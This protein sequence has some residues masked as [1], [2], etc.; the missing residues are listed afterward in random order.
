MWWFW[1]LRAGKKERKLLGMKNQKKRGKSARNGNMPAPYT[2]YKKKPHQ[3][4]SS[5]RMD[6][7]ISK[8]RSLGI[9]PVDYLNGLRTDRNRREAA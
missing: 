1:R 5:E 2:K 3:Y 9:H 4:L 6:E 8:A 7:I